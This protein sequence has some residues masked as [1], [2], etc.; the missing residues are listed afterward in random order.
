MT[1]TREIATNVTAQ[2]TN[3][4]RMALGAAGLTALIAGLMII[5]AP[6]RTAQVVAAIIAV[7]AL[8]AG[9]ANI[10]VSIFSRGAGTWSRV[11]YGLLGLLFVVAGVV[12]L[13]NLQIMA[14]GLAVTL[15]ILVGVLWIIEGVVSLTQLSD[16]GSK[17]WTIIFAVLSIAAGII[18]LVSPIWGAVVLWWLIG[19][20]LV[21]LGITQIVRA[22]RFGRIA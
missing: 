5:A 4:I 2:A 20:S 21:V 8:I 22:F 1:D 10:V 7:Y 17:I 13:Q 19:I 15:S 16:S 12:A 6:T 14:L 9:L 11:G 3:A 18:L